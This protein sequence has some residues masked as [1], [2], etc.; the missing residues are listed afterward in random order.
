MRNLLGLIQLLKMV[1]LGTYYQHLNGVGLIYIRSSKNLFTSSIFNASSFRVYLPFGGVSNIND[2]KFWFMIF[3]SQDFLRELSIPIYDMSMNFYVDLRETLM[4]LLMIAVLFA[5]LELLLRSGEYL[6][7][8]HFLETELILLF[9][10]ISVE[11][12]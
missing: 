6:D 9:Y 10:E 2:P 5:L 7:N 3:E 4:V 8:G 1:S 11:L 12:I